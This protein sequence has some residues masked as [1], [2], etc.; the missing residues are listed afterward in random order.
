M[1]AQAWATVRN[2]S[3][4][5][6]PSLQ[7]PEQVLVRSK[8]GGVRVQTAVPLVEHECERPALPLF[9]EEFPAEPVV[10]LLLRADVEHDVGDREQGLQLLPV[11][12]VVA[13]QVGRVDDDFLLKARP[14]VWAPAGNAGVPGSNRSGLI[15]S[16]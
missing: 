12:D 7:V 2:R 4:F 5:S 3:G 1:S 10:V 15:D 14:V 13:V 8:A 16:W 6:N 11:R 9:L